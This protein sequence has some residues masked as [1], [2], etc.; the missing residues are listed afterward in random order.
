MKISLFPQLFKHYLLQLEEIHM[1]CMYG[2][3]R[4]NKYHFTRK[5]VRKNVFQAVSSKFWSPFT[6][7]LAHRKCCNSMF[8]PCFGAFFYDSAKFC[9][10]FQLYCSFVIYNCLQYWKYSLCWG[11]TPSCCPI[12]IKMGQPL[13][14]ASPQFVNTI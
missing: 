9:K 12:S 8:W 5:L 3:K 10:I 11:L 13:L 1:T 6:W 7:P 2:Y 14:N 4:N